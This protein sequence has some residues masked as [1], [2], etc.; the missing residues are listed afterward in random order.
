MK[1][2]CC[3]SK[4]E[5]LLGL[6]RMY[7][8][9]NLSVKSEKSTSIKRKRRKASSISRSIIS[10]RGPGYELPNNEP[11]LIVNINLNFNLIVN[12]PKAETRPLTEKTHKVP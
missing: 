3:L 1:K 10:R 12:T 9:E 6:S 2:E 5:S 11:S 4:W 7:S 8:K